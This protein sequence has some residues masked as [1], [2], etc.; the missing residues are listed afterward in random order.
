MT[1]LNPRIRK[2]LPLLPPK[3]MF[4]NKEKEFLEDRMRSLNEYL[5]LLISIHE[6]VEHPSLQKFLEIDTNFNPNYEYE[7]IQSANS[8]PNLSVQLPK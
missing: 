3:R 4:Y 7:S 5:K 2:N 6:V 8:L 1:E